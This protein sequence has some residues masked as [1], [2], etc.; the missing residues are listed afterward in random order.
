LAY[1]A[2]GQNFPDALAAGA[3]AAVHGAPTMLVR[4]VSIPGASATELERLNPVRIILLGGPGV[5]SKSVFDA[6]AAYADG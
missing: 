3:A 5:V 6:L 1:V 2:T 4:G